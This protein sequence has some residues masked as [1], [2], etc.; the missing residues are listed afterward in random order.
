MRTKI[1]LGLLP[2]IVLLVI[3]GVYAMSL[4]S[5]L[6]GAI[7]VIL[8]ENYRSVIASQ[9]MK[10]SAERMDSGLF[11]TLVGEQARG[12][13]MYRENLP[14]FRQNLELELSNIT[15][16]GEGE[17]AN[18][19]K[20]LHEKYAARAKE[21]LATQDVAARREMYFG[22]MLPTFT[23][24]KDTAQAILE[25][26][27]KNMQAADEN[28][29]KLARN[30]SSYMLAAIFA[31]TGVALILGLGLQ[32]SILRPIADLTAVAR[33]LGKGNLDQVV[34]VTSRDELGEL[35]DSFNKMAGSLRTYRQ[36]TDDQI[37][38]ARQTTE[39]TF[40][41]LPDPI[42]V[43]GPDGEIK[44][45]NP[46]AA[47]LL[48]KLESKNLP[49][50]VQ[51]EA[52]KVLKEEPDYLPQNLDR[53]ICVRIDDRETFLLPRVAGLRDESG[54]HGA[55]VILQDVTRFRLLDEVKTNLIS[56][57]SHEL[58]TPLTS[59]RMGLYLLLEERIGALNAQQTELLIAARDDSERL[60]RMINDLL[61]LARLEAG[62]SRLFLESV[63]IADVLRPAIHEAEQQAEARRLRI[64]TEIAPNLP[65]VI[66][67]LRQIEHVFLNLISNA[68]KH[69]PQGE[70]ILIKAERDGY[71]GVKFSVIDHGSGIPKEHQHRV[72]DRF[73]R[74]PGADRT[75]AGLGLAI[76]REI[77]S[78]HGGT[79]GVHSNADHGSNFHFTIPAAT[80]P[81]PANLNGATS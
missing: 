79:I 17:A 38:R 12:E 42:F 52:E 41:A 8:R 64:K 15:I 61:D 47:K 46:A 54:V 70:E 28:A 3:V 68:V 55:A 65:P 36:V 62:A 11:F 24:V 23:E 72:F 50:A 34:P 10:E 51:A 44:F 78:A 76:A 25:M 18:K 29:R 20:A 80:S 75:G 60:L 49:V 1:L 27:Q 58:K 16:P 31:G 40:S 71:E 7:D 69:S 33:E 56:T 5:Q 21:F 67:E 59:I 14:I 4:F 57:V 74:V 73:F 37:V 30:S 48:Y 39:S 66:V 19:V 77:V 53:A 43:L 32:R 22:E 81:A 63:P 2:L 13:K 26:N 9:N 6:G 45:T 35:A